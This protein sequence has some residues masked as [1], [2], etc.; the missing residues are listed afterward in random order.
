MKPEIIFQ[1][2]HCS[3]VRELCLLLIAT[4][5]QKGTCYNSRRWKSEGK[6]Y[7]IKKKRAII[8]QMLEKFSAGRKKNSVCNK[9]K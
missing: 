9:K 3:S 2:K 5:S 8:H 4:Y 6:R 7:V 1:S